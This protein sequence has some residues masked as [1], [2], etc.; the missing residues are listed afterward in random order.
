MQQQPAGSREI[1]ALGTCLMRLIFKRSALDVAEF[2]VVSNS[3]I[4]HETCSLST[5]G[6]DLLIANSSTCLCIHFQNTSRR[7]TAVCYM[8]R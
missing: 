1:L 5:A 4:L 8:Q 6:P 7:R 3:M 2:G